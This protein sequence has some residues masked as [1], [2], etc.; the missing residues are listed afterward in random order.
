M[1]TLG[2]K[3]QS[4]IELGDGDLLL[5][6]YA[7]NYG[8]DLE[9]EAFAPGAFKAGIDKFLSSGNS[10][11][12]WHHKADV[13]L[14]K[15]TKLEEH[16]GKGLWMEA[17]MTKPPESSP[18]FWVYE[19]VKRGILRGLSVGGFFVREGAK[20]VRAA[21]T[22]ISITGRPIGDTSFDVVPYSD[23]GAKALVLA[24]IKSEK[25]ALAGVIGHRLDYIGRELDLAAMRI[26]LAEMRRR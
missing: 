2:G 23:A 10:P 21:L 24:E 12:A 22:E 4:V 20:I 5:R 26:R 17:V 9:D 18:H 11:L 7:A 19:G 6:G 15:V 16:P 3:A 1:E 25:A 13:I 8:L 14:G